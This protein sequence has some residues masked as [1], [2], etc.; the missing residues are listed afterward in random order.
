MTEVLPIETVN[1]IRDEKIV[2]GFVRTNF[3]N[4]HNHIPKEI[5]NL[6]LLFYHIVIREIFKHYNPDVYQL[7]SD[8][9]TLTNCRIGFNYSTCYGSQCIPSLDDHSIY[10]WKFEILNRSSWIAI[11]ID[12]TKY[13]RK[14]KGQFNEK[15]GDSKYYALWND[16]DTNRWDNASI[17]RAEENAPEF[18][19]NDVVSM[20]L[21]L[22]NR[23]LSYQ[24]NDD[25]KYIAFTDITVG[26]EIIYCMGIYIWNN[27]DCV[28]LVSCERLQ[29]DQMHS[30]C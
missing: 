15:I 25:E 17:I 7:S 10:L 12:E 3:I 11:G 30:S 1:K 18:D 19:A 4:I 2:Y 16:G 24:K 5:I 21:D 9:L 29:K 20:I 23:T 13:L 14:K 27:G 28:E 6:C 26:D 8:A 22:S